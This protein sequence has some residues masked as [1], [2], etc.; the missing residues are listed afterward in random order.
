MANRLRDRIRREGPIP[1][2]AFMRAALY[3]R[4]HGYYA[5]SSFTTG[6]EGDFA[7]APDV[8]PLMGATLARAVEDFAEEDGRLVEIGPGSGRLMRDI[9][10]ALPQEA[11]DA[12]DVVLVEP[13]EQHREA[14]AEALAGAGLQPRIVG[15]V[16]ELA[17]DRTLVLANE[18]LDALPCEVAR[19][20]EG[21]FQRLVVDVE[22]GSF[23]E[24]W[25]RAPSR[26]ADTIDERAPKLPVGHRYELA[27]GLADLLDG[28]SEA[29]DPGAAVFFDYGDRFEDVWPDTPDGTLR[30]FREHQQ[31]DPLSEPGATDI[32]YDVDFSRVMDLAEARGL[33][34]DAFGPQERLLVHL[35]LMETA[36][37][38]EALMAAKQL[39]VPGTFAGRFMALVLGRGG[40]TEE[41]RLRVD[42]DD[43]GLWDRGLTEPLGSAEGDLGEALEE[44]M[45][46]AFGPVGGTRRDDEAD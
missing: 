44:E 18:L 28:L 40:V 32:T 35:G 2:S 13:F 22:E 39:L 37:E 43:P 8:G 21:G 46:Q 14:L 17:P 26:L 7:T 12:L 15:D 3:D 31:V 11:L 6:R 16:A 30:G 27:T 38:R 4:D 9:V 41:I 20:T 19:R 33:R 23:V 25:Q 45:Q 1:F 34:V 10:D 42:L 36:R 5:Q 24:G 29:V